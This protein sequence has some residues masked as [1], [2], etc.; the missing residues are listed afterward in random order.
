MKLYTEEQVKTA[1]LQTFLACKITIHERYK[2]HEN[3]ECDILE[4]L[5]P[6]ELPSDEEVADKLKL[7]IGEL[8][9]LEHRQLCFIG[10][11]WMKDY[12]KKQG[13]DNTTMA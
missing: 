6:I 5:T 10:A 4:G 11:L 9:E 2:N 7:V 13:N 1:I 8:G 12:I 3:C